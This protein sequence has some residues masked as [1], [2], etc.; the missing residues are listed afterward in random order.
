M[1]SPIRMP[2]VGIPLSSKSVP[3]GARPCRCIP[4]WKNLEDGGVAVL[5]SGVINLNATAANVWRRCDGK[6]TVEE[7]IDALYE[8]FP[9]QSRDRIYSDV[10]VFLVKARHFNLIVDD[11]E[12]F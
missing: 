12:P 2:P 10:S 7:I 9:E 4:V 11:W 8:E 3:P 5:G 1:F 6:A